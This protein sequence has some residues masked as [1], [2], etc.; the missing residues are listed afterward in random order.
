MAANS[1]LVLRRPLPYTE[2]DIVITMYLPL[3]KMQARL[4]GLHSEGPEGCSRK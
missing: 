4:F 1:C 2:E 3:P